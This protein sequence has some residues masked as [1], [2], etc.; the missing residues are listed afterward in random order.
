MGI[1]IKGMDM[2]NCCEQCFLVSECKCRHYEVLTVAGDY[3]TRLVKDDCPITEVPEPHGRLIDEDALGEIIHRMW[4][5]KK[6]RI[7]N[8]IHSMRFLITSQP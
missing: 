6:S 5:N 3:I 7:R 8:T 1:Y 2:P 4:V